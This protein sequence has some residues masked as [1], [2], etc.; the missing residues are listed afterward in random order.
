MTGNRT[1]HKPG[2]QNALV[3]I[4]EKL[5]RIIDLAE[6]TGPAAEPLVAAA[7]VDPKTAQKWVKGWKQWAGDRTKATE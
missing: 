2:D 4:E 1:A 6:K 3:R 7:D 5:D